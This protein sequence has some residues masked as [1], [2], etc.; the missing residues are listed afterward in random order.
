MKAPRT[1]TAALAVVLLTI[2]SARSQHDLHRNASQKLARGGAQLD[3]A[4]EELET[5]AGDVESMYL[6]MVAHCLR[7]DVD[8][9]LG[10]AKQAVAAG[11]PFSRIQAG[12][13]SILAPM[14]AS[15]AY[16]AWAADKEAP[17]VHGPML[18]SMT[19]SSA[20][21]WVRT[22]RP[23]AVVVRVVAAA[24]TGAEPIESKPVRSGAETDL[25]AVARVSGLSPDTSYSYQIHLDG[26]A[27][28]PK[29]LFRT[30]P[31][32]GKP[33]RI[34]I[35]FGGGAGYVPMWERMW[36]TIVANKPTAM[37][38]LGDN[39]YIDDPTHLLPQQYCYYRRQSRPEWRR[40]TSS[41]PMFAIYDDHDFGTNDCIPGPE[42]DKP[43]WKRDVW[44]VFRQNW[45][46]PS[47]G[48]G[49]EQPGC[50]FDFQ[51]GDVH[52][53]MIDG[54]YYRDLKGGS[55]LG[56]VQKA[57]LKKTLGSSRAT[58]KVLASNVPWTPGVKPGSRD[59]WDGFPDERE[60]IF[61]FIHDNNI[62][63]VLLIAADRHRTDIRKI[64]RPR[65]Y[66]LVEFQSSRLT[67][68]HTHGVVKT[69]DLLFGYNKECSFGRIDFDTT[70]EDPL[71]TLTIVNID[72]EEIHTTKLPLSS[73]TPRGTP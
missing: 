72:G 5:E 18:G 71:I 63:G 50:W 52:F 51:I 2:Q 56:P 22:A 54:R 61:S 24:D 26:A 60:E 16:K 25:T 36:D 55:M 64:E 23:S 73:L 41:T 17:L 13:R 65:G 58:F 59:T 35:A 14:Y 9:A 8:K 21:F 1:L 6:L 69:P 67:N 62:N 31:T 19:D 3:R 42:I 37:L 29:A 20:S 57:W 33:C 32:R 49:K 7:K 12:P 68:R 34:R 38:M 40:L 46:N 44:N 70:L 45:V 4:V 11:L 39:V 53:I 30:F 48:G 43:A 15:D 66:D 47:Y 10:Y 27:V 28:G